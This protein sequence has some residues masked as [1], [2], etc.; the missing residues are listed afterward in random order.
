MPVVNMLGGGV[1]FLVV[2]CEI[3]RLCTAREKK[4]ALSRC[5]VATAPPDPA[6]DDSVQIAQLIWYS[7]TV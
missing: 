5:P 1:S 6:V 4:N 2:A 7:N 3:S